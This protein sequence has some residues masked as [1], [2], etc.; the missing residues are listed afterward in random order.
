[1]S[2]RAALSE[3]EVSAF[4][5]R[6]CESATRLFA[7]QGYDAVTLR[8][9]AAD[10]GCSPMTPYRYFDGK[11]E[12]FAMVRVAAFKRFAAC[13]DPIMSRRWPD[14]LAKLYALGQAYIDFALADP[15][16]YRIMFELHQDSASD[17]PDLLREGM[18]SWS[19]I[20]DGVAEAIEAGALNGDADTVAHIFWSAV[21]GLVS[22][23]L[24][25]KLRLG[26]DLGQIAEPLFETL[27]KGNVAPAAAKEKRS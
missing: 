16:A 8:A 18:R 7:E 10:L 6:I 1:M 22:L 19:P 5:E 2:P 20:R 23:E 27:M 15:D 21:H 13:F 25:G 17:H 14:P 11:D 24:A 3:D 4:R 26:R 9:I 12:I